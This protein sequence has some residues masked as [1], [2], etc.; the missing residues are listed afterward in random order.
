M[1]RIGAGEYKVTDKPESQQS[2]PEQTP[3]EQAAMDRTADSS[4]VGSGE[5]DFEAEADDE[6]SALQSALTDAEQDLVTHK[7]AMLRMQAEMENLRKRLIKDLERSRQRA[8]EGFMNDLLPVRDSLERGMEV[9]SD[10]TTVEAMIEGK[11]LIIK[12]LSKVME[13]HGLKIIDP[14]GEVF[15]PELHQAMSMMESADAEPNTVIE[16]LQKGFQLHDRL[17]RPAM[18]IVSKA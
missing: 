17:V 2:E 3:D 1:R 5:V 14:V 18:V 11:G 4:A 10:N 7:D 12:M 13:D 6:L 9:D 8:L 15:N 16:V